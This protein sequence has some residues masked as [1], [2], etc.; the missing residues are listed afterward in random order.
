[1]G[2]LP[3]VSELSGQK[4]EFT[5]AGDEPT[6]DELRRMDA[7][8]RKEDAEF[9]QYFEE[10]YGMS[11]TPSEGSGITNLAGEFF[12]G[13]GR[14]GLGLLGTGAVGAATWVPEEDED[15][16]RGLSRLIG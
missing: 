4:Y 8:I 14:G 7:I 16:T 6:V 3:R 11:A 12:K 10:K 9:A 1:M 5:I 15:P 2:T 13:I